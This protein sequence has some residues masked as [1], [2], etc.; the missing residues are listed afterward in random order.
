MKVIAAKE[1]AAKHVQ[2]QSMELA[3]SQSVPRSSSGPA[4]S[5]SP[6]N[7]ATRRSRRIIKPIEIEAERR[8]SS[9]GEDPHITISSSLPTTWIDEEGKVNPSLVAGT[10]PPKSYL[11]EDEEDARRSG[12]SHSTNREESDLE[13]S[14][15]YFV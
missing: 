14:E 12:R 10:I 1:E 2:R 3:A 8:I 6:K 7:I 4:T 11:S 9:D 15:F 5:D 13:D